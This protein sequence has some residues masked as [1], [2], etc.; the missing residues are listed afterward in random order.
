MFFKISMKNVRKSMKDY[1]V[2]F[3]TLVLGV[4][5]F[6]VFNSL[7]SQTSMMDIKNSQYE[8]SQML[9]SSIAIV[10]V[11]VSFILAFLIIYANKFMIKRRKKELGIYMTLGMSKRTISGMLLLETA[12]IGILALAVGLLAG[13]FL[14]Q[15][16]AFITAKLFGVNI[17]NYHFIFSADAFL[18]SILYFIIIFVVAM[19]FNSVSIS[20]S[21]LIDLL[22]AGR[23]N[24]ELKTRKTWV[25]V[26]FLIIAILLIGLSYYIVISNGLMIFGGF[27]GYAILLCG[28]GTLFLFMALSGF[29]L[30][31]IQKNKK[32]YYKDLNMFSSR[33][34]SSKINTNFV[35][36]TF[37]CMMLFLTM[38]IMSTVTSFNMAYN[39]EINQNLPFDL[40]YTAAHEDPKIHSKLSISDQLQETGIEQDSLFKEHF[41][42][43]LYDTP[44]KT[45]D[46]LTL[47][48]DQFVDEDAAR[49]AAERTANA[50]RLSDFNKIMQ[51]QGK[52]E[53][54]LQNETSF[55]ILS[56]QKPL[57]E[58]IL[59]YMNHPRPLEINGVEYQLSHNSVI[60]DVLWSARF[61]YPDLILVLPD[62]VSQDLTPAMN[63]YIANYD[64]DKDVVQQTI[65]EKTDGLLKLSE[66]QGIVL[67][68][69][70]APEMKIMNSALTTTAIFIGIYLGLVFLIAASAVLALQQLSEAADNKERYTLLKKF[71]ADETMINKSLFVQVVLYFIVPLIF[72]IMHSIVGMGVM[73][74]GIATFG[75]ID[76][77]KSS[78]IAV[79]FM[80][81][82]YGGYCLATYLG[83]KN[84]VKSNY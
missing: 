81:I 70:Y 76:V 62:S 13:I 2:Y 77:T 74:E 38:V 10:S 11:F 19:L 60:K 3:L 46:I 25:S 22:Y 41:E 5:I 32:L 20:R 42:F 12:V 29:L 34:L 53:L 48:S 27:I 24:E 14:S 1:V 47:N 66:E 65:R 52:N 30:K 57:E 49:L 36:M 37:I 18:K 54:K 59:D 72:A 71:G 31:A 7:D 33:Q 82:V 21:Q 79:A 75:Q 67:I 6:Y 56:N 35:S 84:I 45:E 64:G 44:V 28:V 16:L 83:C 15:G 58:G 69:T 39:A 43:V 51:L 23:K 78:G 8:I 17:V 61:G 68:E 80:S 4:C 9:A 50:I 40:S 63:I 73:N 26:I 55:A